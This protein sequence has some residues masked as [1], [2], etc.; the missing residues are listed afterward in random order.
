MTGQPIKGGGA[1]ASPSTDD[2]RMAA[3]H[4]LAPLTRWAH[5]CHA[6][7][8]TLVKSGALP[9]AR[10]ARG[11][12]VGVGGQHSWVVLGD[13]CYDRNAVIVDPTLWSYD[14]DVQGVWVGTYRDGKHTPHGTGSIFQWGRPN[15]ATGPVVELTPREPFSAEARRFLDL[16]G[17]LDQEGWIMLAHAPV[18]NWP[19]G[20]I[21]DAMVE[22]GFGAFI[23][24]DIIGMTTDRNPGG[25]YLA[26]NDQEK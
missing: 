16:L 13:D 3:L 23:P 11:S 8:I 12:C 6:A 24:I 25:A 19:A 20:E 21:I 15:E 26:V 5:D 18:Q 22:S 17:P 10:V 9:P 2:L 4:A 14:D 1:S 7:S